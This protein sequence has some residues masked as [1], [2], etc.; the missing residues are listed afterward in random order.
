M[1]RDFRPINK[2]FIQKSFIAD[3]YTIGY[4]N[5]GESIV[6]LIKMDGE[7]VFSAVIDSFEKGKYIHEDSITCKIL[8]DNK[9]N[10]LNMICWTH[11]DEDHTLGLDYIL[12]NYVNENTIILLPEGMYDNIKGTKC[13]KPV[14]EII[15]NYIKEYKNVDSAKDGM[16]VLKNEK[17]MFSYG[18][19]EYDFE[20]TVLTP[21]S[22]LLRNKILNKGVHGND[23]SISFV[24]EIGEDVFFFSGDIEKEAIEEGVDY[25]FRN[26]P[27]FKYLKLP[28]HGSSTSI[29][30]SDCV[31][32]C[33]HVCSTTCKG[34]GPLKP[35]PIVLKR[36]KDKA[37]NIYIT[38]KYEDKRNKKEYGY[39]E[40]EYDILHSTYRKHLDCDAYRL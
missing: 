23:Y 34:K 33:E 18:T 8:G 19:Q 40:L 36:Y 6:I 35:E 20:I 38:N 2:Q 26:I 1:L 12:N 28:H 37:D 30:L 16:I 11:P 27:N 14:C 29:Q 21:V 7:V 5:Q 24:M 22:T 4:R 17:M 25:I 32:H 9:V 15:D 39:I 10:K 13:S 31:N 3:I